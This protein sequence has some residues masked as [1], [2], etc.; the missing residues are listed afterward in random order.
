VKGVANIPLT[1]CQL[2]IMS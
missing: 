1:F 2:R